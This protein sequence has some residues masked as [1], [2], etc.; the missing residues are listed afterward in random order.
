MLLAHFDS[1]YLVPFHS[2]SL[3]FSDFEIGVLSGFSAQSCCCL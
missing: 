3:E 1:S 2:V